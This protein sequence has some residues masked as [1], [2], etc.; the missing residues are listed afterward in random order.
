MYPDEPGDPTRFAPPLRQEIE[1]LGLADRGLIPEAYAKLGE[2][3]DWE[4]K[5][6]M[7]RCGAAWEAEREAA[8]IEG[9]T[10]RGWPQFTRHLNAL[11]DRV[12]P[13]LR[14]IEIAEDMPDYP[15]R[16]LQAP[17]GPVRVSFVS[18]RQGANGPTV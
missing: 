16:K 6:C 1:A 3:A 13:A 2:L 12:L 17:P 14:S 7:A 15:I 4:G 8:G 10:Y 18:A 5:A 9:V 11:E